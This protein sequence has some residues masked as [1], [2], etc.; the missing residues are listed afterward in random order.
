MITRAMVI[1]AAIE[2]GN[3][4][5]DGAPMCRRGHVIVGINVAMDKG[6]PRCRQCKRDRQRRWKQARRE[7]R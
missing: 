4:V 6:K 5:W 2:T 1:A 7:A 3:A